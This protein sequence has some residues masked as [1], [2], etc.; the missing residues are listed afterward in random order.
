MDFSSI[1]SFAIWGVLFLSLI[2]QLL[3]S[4]KLVPTKSAFIVERL[5]KYS[6]TLGPG[7][8]AL[9]P[10]LDKVTYIQTEKE[11]S[12]DVPPQECFT[13]DNVRVEVDGVMYISV[14]EPVKTSYGVVNYRYA[15]SQLAQTTIRSIIGTI[16]LDRTFEE[17]DMISG[18]VVEVLT[19]AGEFWGI[20]VHRY[21]IKNI[22]PPKT[23]QVAMEKQVSA[24]R[25]RR[26]IIAES[27][28]KMQSRINRSEGVK[29]EMINQSE[30][31]KQRSI[32]EAEGKAS[33]ILA[34]ATATA[35][36]I[37]A[38][39]DAISQ[40]EGETSI[41]LQLSQKYIEQIGKL[42]K[43]ETSV[44]LPSDLTKMD[45]LLKSLGLDI[46]SDH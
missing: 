21:E 2:V 42:A 3:R 22:V 25:E 46:L 11:E 14:S 32:N 4:I 44:L 43:S 20:T 16:E 23:V 24:D 30:G 13:R 27:E 5:G 10:F 1:F 17:R 40:D 31:Q 39:G 33:E 19:E 18:R 29:M 15:A 36:S 8:H 9:I 26:A 35:G 37:E 12:I 7:F 38:L 6:R 41:Q 28:G 34:I 45:E